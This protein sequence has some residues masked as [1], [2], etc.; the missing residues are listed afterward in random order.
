MEARLQNLTDLE[1]AT[2]KEMLSYGF[3]YDDYSRIDPTPNAFLCWGFGGE[4]E[5]RKYRGCVPSLVK[6]GI[7][8]VTKDDGDTMINLTNGLTVLDVEE[9]IGWSLLDQ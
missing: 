5:D 2:L 4:E 8:K 6:K 1:K 9:A 3:A 7:I